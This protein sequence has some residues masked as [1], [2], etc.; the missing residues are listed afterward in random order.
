MS[1]SL[2]D[3]IDFRSWILKSTTAGATRMVIAE[4]SGRSTSSDTPYGFEWLTVD[5]TGSPLYVAG[6]FS[7][8]GGDQNLPAQGHRDLTTID[9]SD[10]L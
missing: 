2:T 4:A 6:R 7:R 8:L 10:F 1:V 9:Q 5:S 3:H